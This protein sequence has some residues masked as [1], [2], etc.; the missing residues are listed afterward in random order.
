MRVHRRVKSAAPKN[1]HPREIVFVV[2]DD[3]DVRKGLKSL[4]QS[5]HLNCQVF[6]S[7]EEFLNREPSNAVSCLVLDVRLDALS[8]LDLQAELTAAEIDIPIVFVSGRSDIPTSVKAMKGGAIEF[9]TKPFRE[10]DLLDAV[11][12]ALEQDR[13]RREQNGKRRALQ[14]R[15]ESLSK[16]EREVLPLVTSG[17]LN[18]QIAHHLGLSLVTAKVHRYKMMAKLGAKSVP[19]LV[20]MALVLRLTS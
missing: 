16:R 7:A 19:D 17:L 18:K 15:W 4:L 5:A 2:D 9:L 14:A 10:Q 12:S 6:A 11:H 3:S 20:K 8:G 1:D 13:H